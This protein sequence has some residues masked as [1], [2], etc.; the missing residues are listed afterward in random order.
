MAR[1]AGELGV[2]HSAASE[3]KYPARAFVELVHC[4]AMRDQTAFARTYQALGEY[5]CAFS[6][7]DRELGQAVKVVLRLS[8]HPA[9]DF[10]VAALQDTARKASLVFAAVG[11]A[12][13]A[14]G[15]DPSEQ[16]KSDAAKTIKQALGHNQ[17]TRVLLAHS[18][19]EPQ[20]DGSITLTKQNLQ[21]GRLAGGDPKTWDDLENKINEVREITR[22]LQR[23]TRDLSAFTITIPDLETWLRVEPY[24]P[25]ARTAPFADGSPR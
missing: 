2:S 7:L 4:I 17:D 20:P 16:W 3:P 9:G 15:S 24:Q 5:F 11:V 13:T 22:K 8:D 19:L 18:Y 6:A 12:K 14:D 1:P 25:Q 10:V 21:A 23:I